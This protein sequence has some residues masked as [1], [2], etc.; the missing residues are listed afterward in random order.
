[1]R[2]VF[3]ASN[4]TPRWEDNLD[5]VRLTIEFIPGFG[6]GERE[7]ERACARAGGWRECAPKRKKQEC[8]SFGDT[9]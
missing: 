7:P 2:P 9:M 1:M 8:E 4:L 5:T 3:L 6:P